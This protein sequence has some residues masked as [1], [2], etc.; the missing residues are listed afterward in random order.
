MRWSSLKGG[1][2]GDVVN[3]LAVF[4]DGTGPALYVAGS[5]TSAGGVAASCI[6]RWDGSSWSALGSG[7]GGDLPEVFALAVFDDGNGPMLYAAGDFASAGGAPANRIAKWN[8]SAWSALGTGVGAGQPGSQSAKALVVHD[9]GH[10][11]ALYV[12]GNFGLAGGLSALGI[13]RWDGSGWSVLGSGLTAFGGDVVQSLATYD[14]GDG[15]VLFAGGKFG[16]PGQNI[17]RWNGTSWSALGS[18]ITS[19]NSN[20]RALAVYDDGRGPA[21]HVGGAFTSAGGIPASALA[22]WDGS[23]WSAV[24]TGA[25]GVVQAL[26]VFADVSG[27]SLAVGGSFGSADG[28]A[29]INLARWNGSS[30]SALGGSPDA[31]DGI[32]NAFA[33]FDDGS[34][35]ALY[36]G[37]GFE[38]AGGI[39]VNGIGKLGG[40]SWSA[41]AGGMGGPFPTVHAL[42]AFDDGSGPALYAGGWFTSAGGAAATNVARW[43]GS[44]WSAL[45]GGLAQRV[46]ALAAFDD[47]SGPALYA[48]TGT[49]FSGTVARWDGSGWS[50]IAAS[51]TNHTVTSLA[52]FDDGSGPALYAGGAFTSIAG[53]PANHI[54]RWDG[55]SWT[56]LGS[57]LT[58]ILGGVFTLVV[59]DDGSGPKLYVGGQFN[60][61]GGVPAS[62][63]ARWDGASWSA[64]GSGVNGP[65]VY[66][67]VTHDDGR[68]PALYAAGQFGK[69]VAKWDGGSN[70]E[71]VGT[72]INDYVVALASWRDDHRPALFVGG[73]F[74]ASPAGDSHLATWGCRPAGVRSG[75]TRMR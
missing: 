65:E 19:G 66:T 5:F 53:V 28:V 43:D 4:D 30:G 58:G 67:L 55:S 73:A 16:G 10:G 46:A 71:A 7:I 63:I 31:L 45:A 1:V 38:A 54:A 44:S 50:T 23:G 39:A 75:A 64:V 48:G 74:T 47:G 33:V 18:G 52:V 26:A 60:T 36:A 59:H 22:R 70:W 72:G 21:L 25:S 69:R 32:V 35:P 42:A 6:A 51:G 34:G 13:A 3:A 2:Q 40:S 24:G 41:L 14:E 29:A 61:A 56:A 68:G 12:G 37:G 11:Q 27:P 57:G 9:D 49:G 20:V 62:R 15:A 17:A 8:G